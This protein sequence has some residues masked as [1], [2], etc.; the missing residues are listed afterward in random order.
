MFITEIYACT[1]FATM[2]LSTHGGPIRRTRSTD[3]MEHRY[4]T[5]CGGQRQVTIDVPLLR[6]NSTEREVTE[7]FTSEIESLLQELKQKF[8]DLERKY[9]S[10]VCDFIIIHISKA[11]FHDL[12][13][14]TCEV[15]CITNHKQSYFPQI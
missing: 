14:V 7:N 10:T 5:P 8:A 9:V 1:I 15:T 13:S 4:K 11:T 6:D 2:V 3:Q 12:F